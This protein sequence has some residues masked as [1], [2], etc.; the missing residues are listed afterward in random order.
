MNWYVRC[1]LASVP[2]EGFMPMLSADA[3]GMGAGFVMR[4]GRFTQDRKLAEKKAEVMEDL[5]RRQ[6]KGDRGHAVILPVR[7]LG[8]VKEDNRYGQRWLTSD[9]VQVTGP[10]TLTSANE[11]KMAGESF[12]LML[13]FYGTSSGGHG[14]DD[15]PDWPADDPRERVE[16]NPYFEARHLPQIEPYLQ[17]KTVVVC[18]DENGSY[19][20]R[21]FSGSIYVTLDADASDALREID[22]ELQ[23]GMI[24]R[25]D[26]KRVV[27]KFPYTSVNDVVN[28][29]VQELKVNP[30][31]DRQ[32][33]GL[34]PQQPESDDWMNSRAYRPDATT[35]K[36]EQTPDE[37]YQKLI[38][39][40]RAKRPQKP[41]GD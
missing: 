40:E 31:E 5:D 33:M 35:P 11:T 41:D 30:P 22:P 37:Y 10:A 9:M 8:Q 36:P 3:E 21:R 32:V 1:K 6:G 4:N 16:W 19:H 23:V 12:F 17:G 34:P 18:G 7:T 27:V 25:E 38:E 2:T 14:W 13:N 39:I 24:S 28:R 20:W 26:L 29:V 15:Q